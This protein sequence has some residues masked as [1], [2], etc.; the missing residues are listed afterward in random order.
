VSLLV[1]V[2]QGVKTG[3]HPIRVDFVGALVWSATALAT[4]NC[5]SGPNRPTPITRKV[6][7]LDI[8]CPATLLVGQSKFCF[9]QAHYSDGSTVN[10]AAVTWSS[11]APNVASFA[12]LAPGKISALGEGQTVVSA[13]YEEGSATA[14]VSVRAE[15]FLT[16]ASSAE[17]GTFQVGRTVTMFL[18]GEYG[19][20]SVENAE[21]H[22]EISDQ[23]GQLIAAGT[24]NIVSKGGNSFVLS[25]TFAIPPSASQ[26]CRTA[27]LQ[28]GG[29][30]LTA[31]GSASL[32]SC[33][34][35]TQ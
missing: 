34:N 16:V 27:V 22:I 21:L 14:V 7:S 13:Q 24:S 26:V 12:A 20:A 11:S 3:R 32:L 1:G 15:D 5:G 17:Q 9:A 33:I 19:V 25:S 23:N 18:V 28:I 4:L 6:T 35:V 29:V 8:S 2:S 31:T 10:P 30:R